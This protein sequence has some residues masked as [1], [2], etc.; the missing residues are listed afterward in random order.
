MDNMLLCC[1]WNSGNGNTGNIIPDPNYHMNTGAK[2]IIEALDSNDL[3]TAF[4][5]VKINTSFESWKNC[6]GLC[7]FFRSEHEHDQDMVH[8]IVRWLIN[9]K[10][11]KPCIHQCD[12]LQRIGQI[13]T[14]QF[15]MNKFYL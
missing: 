1:T 2:Y 7:Y 5:L 13:K 12:H 15:I 11:Y 10:Q 8:S 4:H 6:V 3:K 14:Y 9:K